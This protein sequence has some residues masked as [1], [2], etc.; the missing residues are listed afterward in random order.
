MYS[1]YPKY[2]DRQVCAN[3]EDPDHTAPSGSVWSGL[4][5]FAFRDALLHVYGKFWIWEFKF[6]KFYENTF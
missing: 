2:L 1:N 3:S 4:S 6:F 5:L